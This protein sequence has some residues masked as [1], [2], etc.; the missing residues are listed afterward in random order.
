M[1]GTLLLR[2]KQFSVRISPRNAVGSLSNTTLY[3]LR[4]RYKWGKL[5]W[6]RSV[7]KGTLLLRSKQFFVRIS[8][9]IGGGHWV[10]SL[11]LPAHKLKVVQ[12]TFK[13]VSDGGVFTLEGETIFR[14]CLPSLWSGVT[15]ICCVAHFAHA[16]HAVKVSLI[17]FSVE[18]HFALEAERVF[19]LYLHTQCSGVTKI[20][21]MAPPAY[22]L[23]AVQVRLKS[24]NNV[25]CFILGP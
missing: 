4:M 25:W 16:L 23:C 5:D 24:V 19:R 3:S 13:L 12:V 9:V 8:P 11:V 10:I 17:S 6:C 15:V 22:V 14:P 7:M 1:K 20:C 18:G 21:L 2:P